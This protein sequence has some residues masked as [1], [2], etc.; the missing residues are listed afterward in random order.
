NC[1]VGPGRA[2][3]RVGALL[4]GQVAEVIG[5]NQVGNYWYIREPGRNV[6]CWLWGEYATVT[7]NIG[8]LPVYTPPPTPTPMPSFFATYDGLDFCTGWWVEIDLTNNGGLSFESVALTVRDTVTN[9]V[10]SQH[11]DSFT[12]VDGC[13]VTNTTDRVNPGTSPNISSPPFAYDP[14]GHQLLATITLCSQNGQ[15]GTCLTQ[16]IRF[17]P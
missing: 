8:V 2:Y 17:T 10:V 4:V 12:D 6:T 7:G 5:R 9:V 3:D 14:R 11:S 16:S 15:N 13:S 1:R